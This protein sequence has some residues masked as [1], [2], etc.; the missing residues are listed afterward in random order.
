MRS[1][2][3][4]LDELATELFRFVARFEYALKAAGYLVRMEGKAEPNWDRLAG[5]IGDALF[6]IDDP[7]LQSA[8]SYILD[9]PPKKQ[10][11][12]GGMLVWE[13]NEQDDQPKARLLFT[14]IR[15]VR[16]NLFHGGKFNGR[17]FE[18]VRSKQL[19][20]SSLT[21]LSRAAEIEPSVWHA[22]NE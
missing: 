6:A 2:H 20:E 9:H 13:E 4:D 8:R 22:F 17:W 3:P 21:I 5:V 16:N 11:V 14:H 12:H 10:W 18:P 19:L 15:Q 1:P 7:E